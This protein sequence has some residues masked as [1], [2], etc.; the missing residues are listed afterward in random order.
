MRNR[1]S[2]WGGVGRG[3]HGQRGREPG[4]AFAASDNT[5]GAQRAAGQGAST[6][7]CDLGRGALSPPS[8]PSFS[9]PLSIRPQPRHAGI[10]LGTP[11]PRGLRSWTDAARLDLLAGEMHRTSG[12]RH[13]PWEPGE[14]CVLGPAEMGQRAGPAG[15]ALLETGAHKSHSMDLLVYSWFKCRP[16]IRPGSIFWSPTLIKPGPTYQAPT[17]CPW[18]HI[19]S[20][21]PHVRPQDTPPTSLWQPLPPP[22]LPPLP[23]SSRL[24]TA[25]TI[26]PGDIHIHPTVL[27]GLAL[28][29][30]PPLLLKVMTSA[31]RQ[32]LTPMVHPRPRSSRELQHL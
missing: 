26:I 11:T 16:I 17:V 6:L 29:I 20:L 30:F 15:T 21:D 2:G 27:P 28:S 24:A 12:G 23:C 14:A 19:L 22:P 4:F 3:S 10:A 5:A 32:R 9:E 8:V 18:M 13:G 7:D 1:G 25:V 31:P